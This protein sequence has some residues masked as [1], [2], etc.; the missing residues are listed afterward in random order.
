VCAIAI[1]A[2]EDFN[3][4]SPIHGTSGSTAHLANLGQLQAIFAAYGIVPTYLLT[5][6]AL[7]DEAVVRALRIRLERGQC[8]LGL[9]LHP[10]VTPPFEGPPSVRFSFAGNLPACLE[11][12]KLVSLK[13]KF[14]WCF[15]FH[16]TIYRAGRYG[17]GGET[18]RLLEKH[19]LMIDTSVAPQTSFASQGGPDYRNVD[20]GLFWFGER[21]RLLEVPFC[22]SV[23]GWTGPWASRIYQFGK[24]EQTSRWH[25]RSMLARVRAAERITLSPEG[26]DF[27]AMRRLVRGL[28]RRGQRILTLSFHSSSAQVGHNP[29]VRSKADLH[30]FYDRLSAMLDHLATQMSF[31]FARLE[32]IPNFLDPAPPV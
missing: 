26:N 17:L 13:N 9:Q 31:S 1:D 10:W 27:R 7:E 16:P 8:S 4:D 6:P 20:Y 12:S 32:E 19:G 29:Y 14:T 2:E 22:R 18:A 11:E 23:V 25:F 28:D 30:T 15:G 24:A 3:W 21:R 5:Y